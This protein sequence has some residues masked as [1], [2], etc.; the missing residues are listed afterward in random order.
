LDD[1]DSSDDEITNH[2]QY[3]KIHKVTANFEDHEYVIGNHKDVLNRILIDVKTPDGSYEELW[4]LDNAEDAGSGS[5]YEEEIPDDRTV[6]G[7]KHWVDENHLR[8]FKLLLDNGD[9]V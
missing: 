9:E 1:D 2:N 4:R 8:T 6:I 5:E 7:W 3:I